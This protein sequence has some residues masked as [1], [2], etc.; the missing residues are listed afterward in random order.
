MKNCQKRLYS[1]Q[2]D[3]KLEVLRLHGA[4]LPKIAARNCRE[5]QAV[6][7]NA[8]EIIIDK[9][10]TITCSNPLQLFLWAWSHPTFRT[11][12]NV[13]HINVVQHSVSSVTRVEV[14]W[15]TFY[16]RTQLTKDEIKR[17]YKNGQLRST[18]FNYEQKDKG[19]LG[20]H[21]VLLRSKKATTCQQRLKNATLR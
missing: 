4:L 1:I 15:G 10:F 16:V 12:L 21:Y 8:K 14:C 19:V 5:K 13:A 6:N 17:K 3:P 9:H 18:T 2:G 11:Y 7:A 20:S